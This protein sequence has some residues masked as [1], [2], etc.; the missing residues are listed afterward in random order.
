MD[1]ERG[2]LTIRATIEPRQPEQTDYALREYGVG[3]FLRTFQVGESIDAS[4]INAEVEAGVLT[5]H[6]PKAE[7]A[8]VRKIAVRSN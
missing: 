2:Q 8:R 5:L 3:D 7:A 4:R 1:Y 6:M